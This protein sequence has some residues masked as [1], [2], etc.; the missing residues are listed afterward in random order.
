MLKI[1]GFIQPACVVM[2]MTLDDFDGFNDRQLFICPKERH[3]DCQELTPKDPNIPNLKR[4]YEIIRDLHNNQTTYT[5]G[6]EG[7]AKFE[8]YHD[9][10]KRRELAIPDDENRRGIIAKAIGQMA[11]VRMILHVLD[12]AVE[13]AFQETGENQDL[14]T[15]Q[16]P[17]MSSENTVRAAIAILNH[18]IETKFVLMP[19]EAK[20]ENGCSIQASNNPSNQE[21]ASREVNYDEM[22]DVDILIERYDKYCML[23]KFCCLKIE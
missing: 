20:L 13:E 1:T 21:N 18:V 16:I 12:F 17:K 6:Q 15:R 5:F 10:L 22:F 7:Q 8:E 3:V 19:P 11:R 4:V 2:M 14:R 9:E 23:R